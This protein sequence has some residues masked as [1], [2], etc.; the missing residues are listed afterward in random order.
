MGNNSGALQF[1]AQTTQNGTTTTVT[2]STSVSAFAKYHGQSGHFNS[3]S[4]LGQAS[5]YTSS[6]GDTIVYLGVKSA[7]RAQQHG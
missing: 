6:G 5:S 7:A 4:G 1:S 3:N 2:Y